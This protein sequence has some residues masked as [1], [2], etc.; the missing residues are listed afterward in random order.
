MSSEFRG[1]IVFWGF[2]FFFFFFK[3]SHMKMFEPSSFLFRAFCRNLNLMTEH[4]ILQWW[5]KPW[6]RVLFLSPNKEALKRFRNCIFHHRTF[7]CYLRN[8]DLWK[9]KCFRGQARGSKSH[10][11]GKLNLSRA[12]CILM[13]LWTS[14]YFACNILSE[15]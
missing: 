8:L 4:T 9:R 6:P 3:N 1:F 14:F 5:R 2:T 15:L 10:F 13:I 11:L 7:F 12:N